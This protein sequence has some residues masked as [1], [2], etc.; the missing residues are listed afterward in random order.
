[1]YAMSTSPL[2]VFGT[3]LVLVFVVEMGIM[4]TMPMWSPWPI[5]DVALSAMDAAVLTV[6]LSP[7]IW[8][9]TVRPLKRLF[10]QRGRLLSRVIE[11][12]EQER[13]RLSRDL[14]DDLGQLLTA[15]LVGLRTISDAPD[16]HQ[17]RERA[18]R[19]AGN[20]SES[21][22][23]ARR[24]AHG[25]RT[26]VLEDLGL[27]AALERLV[28][29]MTLGSGV[30]ISRRFESGTTSTSRPVSRSGY[31]GSLRRHSRTLC[32]TRTR[33]RRNSR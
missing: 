15:I 13:A 21:L 9:V 14:H 23:V 6:V 26:G 27:P 20:A 5:G 1:M 16:I 22:E 2:R 17:A 4:L 8:F 33:R 31:I 24:M 32:G 30:P 25:L 19:L 18:Q 10:E 11:V 28:E 29:D 12:Q 3:V 7:A